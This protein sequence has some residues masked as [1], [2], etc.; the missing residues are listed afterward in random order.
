M[1]RDNVSITL[2]DG[3]SREYP[4]GVTPRKIAEDIGAGLAR[5]AIAAV[6]NGAPFD[7]S[8]GIDENASVRILTPRDEE[9]LEIFRHSSAHL[10]AAAVTELFPEAKYGVGPPI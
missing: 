5:Q 8:R 1:S 10:M 3:S 7:L 4:A 6:V 9:T 2:P